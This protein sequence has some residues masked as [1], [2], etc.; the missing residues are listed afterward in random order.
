MTTGFWEGYSLWAPEDLGNENKWLQLATR[1][2]T[3]DCSENVPISS[4]DVGINGKI[5]VKKNKLI[6]VF[7]IILFIVSGYY[8]SDDR[9]FKKIISDNN[10]NSPIDAFKYINLN[11]SDPDRSYASKHEMAN[12]WQPYQ[13]PKY[14]LTKRN[15]IWCDEGAIVLATIVHALGYKT[16]LVDLI[17]V[18]NGISQHT[19]L[20]IYEGERWI[21][22]DTENDI[23]DVSYSE[24]AD[25]SATPRYRTYPRVYNFFI[26]NNFFLKQIA[27]KI[28]GVDG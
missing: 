22:Y 26:Q 6:F 10:L 21:L 14:I 18:E 15:F 16:R 25:Y 28:R 23:H 8:F 1:T 24:S 11:T 2:T 19:V 27:M 9:F 3:R 17:N 7:T 12:L 4:K 20:E 5:N 13:T